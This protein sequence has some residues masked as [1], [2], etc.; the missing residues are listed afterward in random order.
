MIPMRLTIALLVVTMVAS[1]SNAQQNVREKT[2]HEQGDW[3]V[4]EKISANDP[5]SDSCHAETANRSGQGFMFSGFAG[6]FLDIVMWDNTWSL[7]ERS[8][9]FTLEVDNASWPFT[10]EASDT[11]VY[12]NFENLDQALDIMD[13]VSVGNDLVVTTG[14]GNQLGTFSLVGSSSAMLAFT[15]CWARK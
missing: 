12:T 13:D 4:T 6:D 3:I 15:H 7:A 8:V 5:A 14:S 9:R 2:L 1:T 10:A 11:E